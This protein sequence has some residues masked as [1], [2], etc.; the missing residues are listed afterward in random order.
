MFWIL[1]RKL[2]MTR[3]IKGDNFVPVTLLAVPRLKIVW[4]KTLDK[5]WYSAVVVGILEDSVE[6][7]ELKS[8]NRF[9]STSDFTEIEEFLVSDEKVCDYKVWDDLD[10]SS[11][12]WVELVTLEWVS[13]WKWFTWA[14]KKHNFH[15]WPKTHG[16][17]F[18]RALWSIGNRKPRR[19]HKWKKMHGHHWLD[20]V[21]IKKVNVE[22]FNKEIW[23]FAVRWWVPWSRNSLVKII[24]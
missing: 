1:A 11:L 21:T 16:S 15:G 5:D 19:T 17:K 9:L 24:F 23:V 4:L 13:K 7:S 2:E 22:M 20:T 12:E 8:Q 6:N 14:M 3:I 18:H 10:V